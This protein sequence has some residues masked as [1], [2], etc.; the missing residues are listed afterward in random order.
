MLVKA[1]PV[2]HRYLAQLKIID[3]HILRQQ[4]SLSVC[5]FCVSLCIVYLLSLSVCA[6]CMW[7][8]QQLC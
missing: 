7:F 5:L 1:I 4:V 3:V 6:L 2:L 8:Q